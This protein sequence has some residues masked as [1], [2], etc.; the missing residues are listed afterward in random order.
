[1]E[2]SGWFHKRTCY[3]TPQDLSSVWCHG[4]QPG[5]ANQ[6]PF[7]RQ[8][9]SSSLPPL[10]PEH[11]AEHPCSLLKRQRAIPSIQVVKTEGA[12]Q[13]FDQPQMMMTTL[14][15]KCLI[16]MLLRYESRKKI[17]KNG[18]IRLTTLCGFPVRFMLDVIP[19]FTSSSCHVLPVLFSCPAFFGLLFTCIWLIKSNPPLF[20]GG[21][22]YFLKISVTSVFVL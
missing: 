17:N 10:C 12:R 1:M 20:H 6:G 9:H 4:P 16:S 21:V 2:Q 22:S 19:L 3:F 8:Q 15:G 14:A 5:L 13:R 18:D 11:R 7:L